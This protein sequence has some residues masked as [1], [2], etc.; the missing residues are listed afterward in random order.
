ME[1]RTSHVYLLVLQ[2][3]QLIIPVRADQYSKETKFKKSSL[4]TL[5]SIQPQE[6]YV[7]M[8]I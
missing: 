1:R 7:N 6:S 4:K 2:S 5:P 8:F 3:Q